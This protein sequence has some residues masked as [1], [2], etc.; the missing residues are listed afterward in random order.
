MGKALL[1]CR[2]VFADL[3]RRPVE[4]VLLVLAITAAAATLS[5]GLALGGVRTS[6]YQGTRAATHG[7]D[8]VAYGARTGKGGTTSSADL[9]AL[10]NLARAPGVSG[11]SP[12]Y[13]VARPVLRTNGKT[14]GV[15]A[16]GRSAAPAAIDQPEVT[17]GTWV[18][19]GEVVVERSF[20]DALGI[21]VGETV[22]LNSR[23]F[24]VAGIAVTATFPAYPN[25]GQFLDYDN[26]LRFGHNLSSF[27]NPGAVWLTETDA[28]SLAT[29]KDP[30][31]YVSELKLAHP[32][33]A[34]SFAP[35]VPNAPSAPVTICWQQVRQ[36]DYL[37]I[38]QERNLLAIA[39]ALLVLLAITSVAVLVG[40]R[41]ADQTRRVGRLKAAGATPSLVAGVLV[42]ENSVLAVVAGVLGLG[43]GWL[44]APLVESPGSGLVAATAAPSLTGSTVGL[45]VA[46]A[47][48]VSLLATIVPAV[49]AARTSTVSALADAG[50][51]PKRRAWLIALS[52]RLPTVL[53]LGLRLG[54]RRLRRLGLGV[55]SVA[56]TTSAVVAALAAHS[57]VAQ[58]TH[59]LPDP[60]TARLDQLLLAVSAILV[61]LAVINAAFIAWTTAL[62]CRH[63]LAVMRA[64]GASPEETVAS[65]SAA[66]LVPALCGAVLGIPGG[67]A[68]YHLA[69]KGSGVTATPAALL[70]IAVVVCAVLVITLLAAAAGRIG[71]SRPVVQVLQAETA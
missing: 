57:S 40:G 51:A 33:S 67:L 62:D 65:V 18:R 42:A 26:S 52:A 44:A 27:P 38:T 1:I 56:I 5:L 54:A 60:S 66:Q 4:A 58:R 46:V 21:T 29:V 2:L 3:R 37:I 23:P 25:T 31:T 12:L 10:T 30:L 64:L 15:F 36:E 45:V 49:R 71:A 47:L 70:L 19:N 61:L 41:M 20:A 13:A 50:G 53:L 39:S 8:V 28:R 11:H 7:A 68:L 63:P 35:S 59:G 9:T 17:D 48:G 16:I 43:I 6:S 24:R 14:D 55:V 69:H 32:A 22:T 34:C